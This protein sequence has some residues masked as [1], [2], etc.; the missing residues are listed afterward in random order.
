MYVL[1]FCKV[2]WCAMTLVPILNDLFHMRKV[3][4]KQSHPVN[5]HWYS[6]HA[7]SQ[8]GHFCIYSTYWWD[9]VVAKN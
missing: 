7:L 1:N 9:G 6:A 5:S 8:F 3:N 2:Q 4:I